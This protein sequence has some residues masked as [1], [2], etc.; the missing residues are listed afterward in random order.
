MSTH[1]I[2]EGRRKKGLKIWAASIDIKS[3]IRENQS[4][5]DPVILLDK[6]KR[7]QKLIEMEARRVTPRLLDEADE[8][9]DIDFS[10]M[11]S[12][13]STYNLEDFELDSKNGVEPVDV[14]NGWLNE[15]YDWADINRVWLG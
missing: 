10:E 11:L 7:I 3:I 2:A 8:L 9:C 1:Q 15:I 13:M 5:E 4:S 6:A 12:D 14:F